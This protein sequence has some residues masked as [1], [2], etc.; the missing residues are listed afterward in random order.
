[1]TVTPLGASQDP[2]FFPASGVHELGPAL[3]EGPLVVLAG[4]GFGHLQH[5][6][7]QLKPVVL[8]VWAL[9]SQAHLIVI[10]VTPG[11]HPSAGG[12]GIVPVLHIVLFGQS[13]G[14]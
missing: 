2:E 5:H 4:P 9:T 13:A 3:V 1:M 6:A 14:P 8:K 11:Y 7:W 10:R 12:M